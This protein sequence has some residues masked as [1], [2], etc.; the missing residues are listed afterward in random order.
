MGN[1]N[2]EFIVKT[3]GTIERKSSELDATLLNIIRI[4]ANKDNI[5]AAYRSQKK[6]YRICKKETKRVDYREYV[7]GL[8]LDNFPIEFKKA[9]L[10]RSYVNQYWWLLLLIPSIGLAL[11]LSPQFFKKLKQLSNAIKDVK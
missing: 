1:I 2:E 9:E 8:Q 6:C 3:D 4:G 7:Q 5:L 11:L 10:G